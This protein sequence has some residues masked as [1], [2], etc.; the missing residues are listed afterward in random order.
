MVRL[1]A[2]RWVDPGCRLLR[3]SSG[4]TTGGA[5]PSAAPRIVI[6]AK[7]EARE[8]GTMVPLGT[9]CGAMSEGTATPA[10]NASIPHRLRNGPRIK[11]GVTVCGVA[12]PVGLPLPSSPRRSLAR[13][14]IRGPSIGR[15]RAWDWT[16]APR[17]ACRD[18]K[19]VPGSPR[20]A[21]R[22]KPKGRGDGWWCRTLL[23]SLRLSPLGA[24]RSGATRLRGRSPTARRRPEGP[25]VGTVRACGWTPAQGRGD[26][27]W[28]GA[29]APSQR[30][31]TS[32]CHHLG[33]TER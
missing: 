22:D 3:G 4:V 10:L 1:G 2:G 21:L 28:Y 9:N 23:L 5:A 12:Q 16:P 14:D 13:G 26:S 27:P 32:G 31:P 24:P 18:C 19:A 7:G 33:R 8:P 6:P 15:R 17:L 30:F 29:P 11:S 20:M 25:A